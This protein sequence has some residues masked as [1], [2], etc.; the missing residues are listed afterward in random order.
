MSEKII[1]HVDMDAFFTSVE[2]A[3]NPL[4]RGKPVVVGA[5]PKGGRGRGVVSAA[6]YEARRFG[7]HSAMPISK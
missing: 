1:L 7:I 3:D 5:D 2:Q 6:S 4:L